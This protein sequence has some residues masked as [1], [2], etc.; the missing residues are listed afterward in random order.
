MNNFDNL[1]LNSLIDIEIISKTQKQICNLLDF[2]IATTTFDG[3]LVDEVFNCISFC[4]LIQSSPKGKALCK[5]SKSTF[6]NTVSESRQ[7]G[8]YDCHMGLK[9]FTTPII[10]NNLFL[11]SVIVGQFLLTDEEVKKKEFDVKK[12]S[13]KFNISENKL[14]DSISKIPIIPK[15]RLSKIEEAS[16]LLANSFSERSIKC[17]T[18]K[19][20]LRQTEETSKFENESKKFQ[21]K[22]LEAQINPHFLFNTLNSIARMALFENSPNTEEMIYCLSDLLRYNIKQTEEFPTI[23]DELKNIERYLFIQGIRYKDRL[24]YDIEVPDEV[25]NFRIPS[26]V[27]QP[28]VENSIIHGIEPKVSGGKIYIIG[29]IDN[30]NIKITIKDSGVGISVEKLNSILCNDSL[31]SNGLG[32]KSSHNRLVSY[33]GSNYGLNISST[34]NVETVV[35]IKLP[36]FKELVL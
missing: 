29:E 27:L 12:F 31:P 11:G 30:E 25:L 24:S 14:K 23:G 15:E 28:I 7:C 3:N 22:T 33:F 9:N 17:I 32:T 26:M 1:D 6:N 35:E 4:K 36:C 2:S 8:L 13:K 20:L 10:A 5:K 21:L 19:K 34:K 16:S 18:E